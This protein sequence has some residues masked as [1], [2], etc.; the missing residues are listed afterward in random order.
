MPDIS[1]DRKRSLFNTFPKSFSKTSQF[2]KKERAFQTFLRQNASLDELLKLPISCVNTL[3]LAPSAQSLLRH[4][5]VVWVRT[6]FNCYYVERISLSQME[7]SRSLYQSLLRSFLDTDLKYTILFI[8]R[9]TGLCLY[10][11]ERN[12]LHSRSF[13]TKNHDTYQYHKYWG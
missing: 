10:P 9:R 8:T 3:T 12:L 11:N 7:A 2:F 6:Y 1:I 4:V 13:V 5:I